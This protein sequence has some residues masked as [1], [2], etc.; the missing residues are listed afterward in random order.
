MTLAVQ[1]PRKDLPLDRPDQ[2]SDDPPGIVLRN[3]ASI[4][5]LSLLDQLGESVRD[6][7]RVI[8]LTP[9]ARQRM[10]VRGALNQ[11]RHAGQS[12]KP[13]RHSVNAT[14]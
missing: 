8:G 5:A 2:G 4:F 10:R 11:R 3:E 1:A 13:D 12:G 7:R 6:L 14:L 9:K